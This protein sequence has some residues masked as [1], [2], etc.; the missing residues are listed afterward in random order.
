MS[1]VLSTLMQGFFGNEQYAEQINDKIIKNTCQKPSLRG[2]LTTVL[3]VAI[4]SVVYKFFHIVG[5]HVVNTLV[6]NGAKIG[7][8][9]RCKSTRKVCTNAHPILY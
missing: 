6:E 2:L 7:K 4:L 1:N 5:K 3:N 8:T 9:N